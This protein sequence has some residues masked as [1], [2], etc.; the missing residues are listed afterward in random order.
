[1]TISCVN[2]NPKVSIIMPV[3]N[4]EPFL[5][6]AIE[7]VINQTYK[8]LEII[9][10]DDGSS[11]GSERICDEYALKDSRIK[12]IHKE[13]SG[14]SS[15]RNTGLDNM[16]GEYVAFVDPDDIILPVAIEKS[17][18]AMLS[19]DVDCVTFKCIYCKSPE[20]FL[21]TEI[22][23][24][25]GFPS[26]QKGIYSGKEILKAVAEGDM[27]L[28]LWTKL[29]KRKIWENL[30][31]P[32]G[33]VY[34]DRYIIFQFFDKMDKILVLSDIFILYRQRTGSI[35]RKISAA[36]IQGLLAARTVF[37]NYIANH[38][39]I[40]DLKQLENAR[41]DYLCS[42]VINSAKI[43]YSD[44]PEKTEIFGILKEKMKYLENFV[45]IQNCSA[46]IK[47][48]YFMIFHHP[49]ILSR[50]YPY[51]EYIIRCIKKV[52]NLYK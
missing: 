24:E 36:N 28:F 6:S 49:K 47:F 8:N 48:K 15:A 16:S 14:V 34:E 32:E 33:K 26:M 39:E 12:L 9:L 4:V 1:M 43:L 23:K 42:C 52:K 19:N 11:D 30:R 21:T 5:K 45:K 51:F 50:F 3:Y 27:D 37:E 40:F 18:S 7:S 13:N 29:S 10:V 46:E 20:S 44:I 22:Q 25:K 31:F 41:K 2:A 38:P 17:V 35:T